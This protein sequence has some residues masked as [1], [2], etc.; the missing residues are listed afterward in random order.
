MLWKNQAPTGLTKCWSLWRYCCC[1]LGVYPLVVAPLMTAACLLSLYSSSGCEFIELSVGFTPINAAMNQSQVNLGL[2]Y[3]QPAFVVPIATEGQEKGQDGI[4]VQEEGENKYKQVLFE[5]CQAYT[6][7]ITDDMVKPDRTWKI[8]RIMALIAAGAST[9]GTIL[10]WSFVVTPLSPNYAWPGIFLPVIMIAFI[11]EGSKFLIFDIALCRT[12]LWLPSGV[13][14]PAQAAEACELGTSAL[15]A[16][17]AG[18]VLLVVLL[19]VCLKAPEY[20]DLDPD[21]GVFYATGAEHD[22][23]AAAAVASFS[24]HGPFPDDTSS[25]FP[26]E[27]VM[28]D[29]YT[30]TMQESQ[31]GWDDNNDDGDDEGG[32]GTSEKISLDSGKDSDAPLIKSKFVLSD[33]DVVE[34]TLV[35]TPLEQGDATGKPENQHYT[36]RVSESRLSKVAQMQLNAAASESND[37]MIEQLVTDLNTS[38]QQ[39]PLVA[40]GIE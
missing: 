11:A 36:E 40:E 34:A 19:G 37:D 6:T 10:A 15:T 18:A 27:S 23:E 1:R 20:R 12:S 33:H 16:I 31:S 38:F 14:S 8:A 29:L 7:D 21:Y 13:D 4:I 9:L 35:A 3:Y 39:S 32:D 26:E 2:F 22:V 30:N 17:A 5:G 24:N 28:D 25:S